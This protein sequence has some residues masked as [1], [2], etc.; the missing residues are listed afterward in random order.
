MNQKS[1][2]PAKPSLSK[3]LQVECL[4]GSD[5]VS[6]LSFFLFFFIAALICIVK[7]GK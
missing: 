7:N 6:F 4:Q 5:S 3:S 2:E 1:N